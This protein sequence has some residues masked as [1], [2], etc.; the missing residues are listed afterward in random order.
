[1]NLVTDIDICFY[2]QELAR[3]LFGIGQPVDDTFRGRLCAAM[4]R[5]MKNLMLSRSVVDV[6]SKIN[7][8]YVE[9][10]LNCQE[11]KLVFFKMI[12]D[13]VFTDS[14]NWGRITVFYF[15]AIDWFTLVDTVNDTTARFVGTYI[16][17]KCGSWIDSEGGWQ[18]Y[19]DFV[20]TT[21]DEDDDNDE[22]AKGLTFGEKLL[23]GVCLMFAVHCL[24]PVM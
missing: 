23:L 14:I 17:N 16:T 24:V 15:L 3:H 9:N 13:E 22:E 7:R 1:M 20:R 10:P 4:D 8:M 11:N 19:I 6:R 18:A 5:K 21:L 12:A 2:A